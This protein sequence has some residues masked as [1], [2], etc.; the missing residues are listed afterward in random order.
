MFFNFWSDRLLC[1]PL[2]R[3]NGISLS[4]ATCPNRR[5]TRH[6]VVHRSRLYIIIAVLVWFL[7]NVHR[8]CPLEALKVEST[9]LLFSLQALFCRSWIYCA[10]RKHISVAAELSWA[11][12]RDIFVQRRQKMCFNCQT[13]YWIIVTLDRGVLLSENIWSCRKLRHMKFYGLIFT[14][15]SCVICIFV[16]FILLPDIEWLKQ[17]L[18]CNNSD[19]NTGQMFRSQ[20]CFY[21]T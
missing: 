6:H 19:P 2:D 1:C 4:R 14:F 5:Q 17:K 13:F 3:R 12:R 7:I 15:S 9:N 11:Q 10:C 20:I 21:I 18:R 16:I 8:H